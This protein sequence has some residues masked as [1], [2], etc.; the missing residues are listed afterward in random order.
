MCGQHPQLHEI[1]DS[2]NHVVSILNYI[3]SKVS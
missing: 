1:E 2:F 3:I